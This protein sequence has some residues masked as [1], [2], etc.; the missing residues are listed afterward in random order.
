MV[1]IGFSQLYNSIELSDITLL[2]GDEKI[3]AHKIGISTS[4]PMF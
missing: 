4:S 2:L 3:P 1:K